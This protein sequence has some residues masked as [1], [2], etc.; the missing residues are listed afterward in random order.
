MRA[1]RCEN[2]KLEKSSQDYDSAEVAEGARESE[3]IILA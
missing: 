1:N 2:G 3:S